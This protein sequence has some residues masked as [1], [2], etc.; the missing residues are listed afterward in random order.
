MTGL[1]LFKIISTVKF[2]RDGGLLLL[3]M[4]PPGVI[5][6]SSVRLFLYIFHMHI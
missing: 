3:Q 1:K 2:K 4:C 5:L 6:K